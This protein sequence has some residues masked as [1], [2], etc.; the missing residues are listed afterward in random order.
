M[1]V[2]LEASEASAAQLAALAPCVLE[3]AAIESTPGLLER[4][5]PSDS[6]GAQDSLE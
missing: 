1:E 6:H 3:Q 2:K 4:V 5:A